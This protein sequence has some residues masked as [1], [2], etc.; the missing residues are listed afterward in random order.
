MTHKR[1]EYSDHAAGRL[2]GRHITRQEVRWLLA[3]GVRER[4]TGSYWMVRGDV[5]GS[6]CHVVYLENQERV[7]VVTVE[8][9]LSRGQVAKLK[10]QRKKG[11]GE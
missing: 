7:L 6:E 10:R 8:W 9:K 4:L 2:P 5:G 3:R 11:K 1:I